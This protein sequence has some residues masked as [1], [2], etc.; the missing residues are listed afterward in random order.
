MTIPQTET[1]ATI[2][3]VRRALAASGSVSNLEIPS[4]PL[5]WTEIRAAL[6]LKP[7]ET[8]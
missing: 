6:K 1:L 2:D 5:S 4:R 3:E 7:T 8:Q